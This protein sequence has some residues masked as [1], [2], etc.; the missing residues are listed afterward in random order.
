MHNEECVYKP[1][2][3]IKI[4]NDGQDLIVRFIHS[5]EEDR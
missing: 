2:K 4:Y 3:V 1:A 5:D